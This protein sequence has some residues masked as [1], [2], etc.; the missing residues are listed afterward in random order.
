M[1][2]VEI[3]VAM[4]LPEGVEFREYQRVEDGHGLLVT[5]VAAD[6]FSC[7][8][9]GHEGE[10]PARP[11]NTF[12]TC[13]DLDLWG[14]PC[15]LVYQPLQQQCP[16]CGRRQQVTPPFKRPDVGHSFR[17]EGEVLRRLRGSTVEQV[18]RELAIDAETVE[19]IAERQIADAR[20]KA[21]DP[22]RVVV[23]VGIDEFS[24]RKGHRLYATLL[25]D[26]TDA[27]RPSLLAVAE[28]KDERAVG[29]CLQRLSEAQRAAVTTLRSDMGAAMLSAPKWLPNAKTVID[30]FHVAQKLGKAADGL[31][32]KTPDGT[33]GG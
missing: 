24:L 16:R 31:R 7:G 29:E 12:Y 5:Y 25:W 21:V 28:G 1:S 9:C 26:L 2:R 8:R 30:R 4:E 22:A 23:D 27:K 6:R 32:K 18:A 3:P 13:R 15:F 17:F 11:R 14:E 20:G 10:A 19:R 33:S